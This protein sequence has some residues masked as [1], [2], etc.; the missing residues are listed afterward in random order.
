MPQQKTI[1]NNAKELDQETGW[2]YYGARYYDPQVSRWLSVDPLVEKYPA[3]SPYN[4]TMNNP[5][6]LV[7]ADGTEGED[8]YKNKKTGEVVW[9]NGSEERQG[10]EHLGYFAGNTDIDGNRTFYDGV[11]QSKTV[12]GNLDSYL[13][14]L[15]EVNLSVRTMTSFKNRLISDDR[16]DV[17]ISEKLLDV[18][19]K[20]GDFTTSSNLKILD[21]PNSKGTI[22]LN[23]KSMFSSVSTDMSPFQS[24][25]MGNGTMKMS[26]YNTMVGFDLKTDQIMFGFS[27]PRV[28]GK[29]FS[30]EVKMNQQQVKRT[31]ELMATIASIILTKRRVISSKPLPL[32]LPI[33]RRIPVLRRIPAYAK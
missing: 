18:P 27:T 30:F 11:T 2:Y 25:T 13:F 4:F 20:Y 6:R 14:E 15:P 8:W 23:R 26:T 10:Y 19:T 24:L 5:V 3:F 17:A 16:F 12:N 22:N 1:L 28:Y 29:K 31:A 21:K 7:D 9:F 33:L 32:P